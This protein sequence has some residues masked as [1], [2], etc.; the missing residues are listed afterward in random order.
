V[1]V[2]ALRALESSRPDR[3]FDDPYAGAFYEAGRPLLPETPPERDAAGPAP[4]SF[5]ALFA[6]PVAVRTRQYDDQLP[7]AGCPQVVLLAAGLDT[8]AFRLTWPDGTRLFEIDLPEVLRFK[9]SVLNGLNSTPRCHRTEVAADLREDWSSALRTA[10]FQPE[11]P[12]AWLAEGLM[13]YLTRDEAT[14][15]LAK[16]T[17]LSAPG[18]RVFF[19]DRPAEVD[20]ELAGRLRAA[21][22]AEQILGLWLGGLAGT[23]ADWLAEHGWSTERTA[24]AEVAEGYGRSSDLGRLYNFVAARR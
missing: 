21:P 14:E 19:E 6:L 12:T 3:L 22:G 20:A 8:R 13:V 17:A 18:S 15:L 11:V 1:G 10:G 16:V 23:G 24:M 5:G 2:A 9:D 4:H 7:A